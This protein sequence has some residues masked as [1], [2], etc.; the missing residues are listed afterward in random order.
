MYGK[1]TDLALMPFIERGG[2]YDRLFW[3][4]WDFGLPVA[5]NA[6]CFGALGGACRE[7]TP[8]EHR[9]RS[10]KATILGARGLCMY[11]YRCASMGTWRQMARVG[12]EMRTLA[13]I[14]LTP[15]DRLRV[16]VTPGAPDVFALLKAHGAKHYLLAVNVNPRPVNAVF[17]LVDLP[18][19]GKVLPM[20]DTK[21]LTRVNAG[22]KSVTAEMLGQSVAI[23]EIT[24]P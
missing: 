21:A 5:T 2:R 15:D 23:Y 22:A 1:A 3:E 7:P 19:V 8:A 18:K 11:T 17:R 12:K 6:P 24:A 20:F 9:V 10:Y 13:P 14:L 4:F 16:D